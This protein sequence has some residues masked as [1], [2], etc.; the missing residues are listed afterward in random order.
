MPLCDI[1]SSLLHRALVKV[2]SPA[3]FI[4][5][6]VQAALLQNISSDSTKAN[7][8]TW[9]CGAETFSRNVFSPWSVCCSIPY[10]YTSSCAEIAVSITNQWKVCHRHMVLHANKGS[11][12]SLRH[13]PYLRS[14][15]ALGNFPSWRS[16][17][18]FSWVM[19]LCDSY[20]LLKHED[21]V[22]RTRLLT[23][24]GTDVMEIK[25]FHALKM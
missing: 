19:Y 24:R 17:A 11:I 14:R 4:A 5:S 2:C 23:R 15:N 1:S 13:L 6:N 16:F 18:S 10:F 9:T 3:A 8:F 25:S 20:P 7:S 22:R 12:F 21:C